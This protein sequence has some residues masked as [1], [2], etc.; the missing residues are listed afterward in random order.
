MH[1][2]AKPG[3]LPRENQI[4][5]GQVEATLW[6]TPDI[7]ESTMITAKRRDFIKSVVRTGLLGGTGALAYWLSRRPD[8]RGAVRCERPVDC[9]GCGVFANCSLPKATQARQT[10][11]G[12]PS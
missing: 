7:G 3:K 12:G 10:F 8:N 11:S 1:L 5:T 4:A 6:P 9:Q 2:A